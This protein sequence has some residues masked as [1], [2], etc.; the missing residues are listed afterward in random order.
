MKRKHIIIIMKIIFV[1]SL[2]MLA[3]EL[4]KGYQ[5]EKDFDEIRQII[6]E[7]EPTT[8]SS[9]ALPENGQQQKFDKMM[10]YAKL[11]EINNEFIGWIKIDNT[12][13]DYPVMHTPNDEEY[14]LHRNF[15]KEYS[16]SGTP[17]LSAK[18]TLEYDSEQIIVYGH[19]MRN[20]S[21]FGNLQLYKDESF[22][23]DN[24]TIY[25]DT[26]NEEDTYEIFTVFEIDVEVGNGHFPFYEYVNFDNQASLD[27]FLNEVR[28]LEFYDTGVLPEYGDSILSLITCEE[29]SGSNRLVVMAVKKDK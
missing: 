7:Q 25:F 21:M 19:N 17:F 28:L 27:N 12:N 14:Y 4:W 10:Q 6:H 13:L 20:G 1:C 23:K 29:Y 15:N 26:L 2:T 5:E 9:D 11:A 16:L 3:K 8:P 24:S 22:Y 18:N